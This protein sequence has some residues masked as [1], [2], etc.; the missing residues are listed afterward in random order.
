MSVYDD[1][2]SEIEPKVYSIV[3]AK[4]LNKI[5]EKYP[6]A[7]FTT[8]EENVNSKTKFPTIYIYDMGGGGETGTDLERDRINGSIFTFQVR[9]TTNTSKQD[10]RNVMNYI[11]KAFK[12]IS[13]EM[14]SFPNYTSMDGMHIGVARFRRKIDYNDII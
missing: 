8:T 3:K 10:C 12:D 5:K 11:I 6:S 13:F 14:V 9:I 7:N 4:S 2:Y 1:W